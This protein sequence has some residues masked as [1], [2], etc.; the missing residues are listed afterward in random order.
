MKRCLLLFILIFFIVAALSAEEKKPKII[1]THV[2]SMLSKPKYKKGFK[3]FDYVNPDAPKGGMISLADIGTF[4]NFN[5]YA[6]RG[7]TPSG[8]EGLYDTLL[9]AS[10]DEA[11]VYYGLVAEQMEYPEDFTWI[12]YHINPRAKFQDGK[13]ITAN[14][15]AFSFNKFLEQGVPQ[16]KTYYADV[17]KTEALDKKRVKYTLKQGNKELLINLGTNKILP[18]HFWKDHDLSEPLTEPPLGSGPY[19]I[20]EYK[21]GQYIIYERKKDYWARNIP[22]MKGQLNFDYVRIDYYRDENVALEA[23]KAGEY[24]LRRENISKN[25]ATMYTGAPFDKK[26]IVKEEIPHELPQD[27]QAMIFNIKH[28]LFT[29]R[30]VRMALNYA[31]DFEWM[32]KNLFYGQY[33]RTRSYFQNTNYEAKGLPGGKE[34]EILT[35]LKD[36]I[37]EEVFTT[38]YRPPVTDGSGNIRNNIREALALFKQAGWEMKDNKL[39]NTKT[40]KQMEF[41]ILIY[42]P[43]TERVLI[44]VQKNMEKMGVTM[45]IRT[46]DTTQFIN[47]MR[48]REFD[49]ISGGYSASH[50]PASDLKIIWHSDYLD[51]TWNT[52]GVQDTAVDTLLEGIE[53][54]QGNEEMLITY[55]RALDRVLTWNFYVIPEWHI[56]TFRV[57]YWNKFSRPK[58]R[59]KY[60]LGLDTWWYDEAKAKK[61][62]AKEK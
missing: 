11:E 35:P 40:G 9:V 34:L 31:L 17:E 25:W 26:Y 19:I 33:T 62:P 50:Y 24:D 29:D 54:Y 49:M 22:A 41:E 21:M 43:A 55:G 57:A 30:L 12:I 39:T 18:G 58:V 2:M 51:Y 5:R 10:L 37:P 42:S 45:A 44:P 27:M 23:L 48:E 20:K 32:N 13:P 47:R 28:P 6:Q 56:S 1:K 15:I 59:P 61:L 36:T 52:A 16:F 60:D 14:D 46:V 4:D 53:K 3:H 38:E 7:V 8:I